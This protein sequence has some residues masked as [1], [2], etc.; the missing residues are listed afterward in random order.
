MGAEKLISHSRRRRRVLFPRVVSVLAGAILLL[1]VWTSVSTR[2]AAQRSIPPEI[3]TGWRYWQAGQ[4]DVFTACSIRVFTLS[5]ET[6]AKIEQQ[7][8][9]FFESV[10][11]PPYEPGRH[12]WQATPASADWRQQNLKGHGCFSG[13]NQTIWAKTLDAVQREGSFYSIGMVWRDRSLPH[14]YS[15]MPRL[16]LIGVVSSS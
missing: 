10:A 4:W 7:G 8:A 1:L 3:E 15:V 13:L 12:R 2:I 9:S 6:A 11:L 16:G 5:D 14:Y